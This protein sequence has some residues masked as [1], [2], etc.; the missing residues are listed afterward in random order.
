LRILGQL[1]SV[2]V[3]PIFEQPRVGDVR[4]SLADIALA[5]D[6]LGYEPAV[7]LEDGLRRSIDYY[8][9]IAGC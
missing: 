3:E 5:R 6:K 2:S 8:R 7:T 1:L 4:E 9:S